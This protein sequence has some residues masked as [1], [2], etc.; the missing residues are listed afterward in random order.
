MHQARTDSSIRRKKWVHSH[1]HVLVGHAKN[2]RL[3]FIQA[4]SPGL[5]SKQAALRDEVKSPS[6]TIN[7]LASCLLSAGWTPQCSSAIAQPTED[8]GIP[9]GLPRHVSGTWGARGT[10]AS[11]CGAAHAAGG[12]V[13][14]I[15]SCV[16]PRSSMSSTYWLLSRKSNST[17]NNMLLMTETS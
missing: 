4:I 17:P 10:D 1:R 8:A 7:K 15:A 5:N 11:K 16:S 3:L 6:G 12:A 14:A 9:R 2:T 13:S